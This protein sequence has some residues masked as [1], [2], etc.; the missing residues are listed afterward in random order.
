MPDIG[1]VLSKSGKLYPLKYWRDLHEFRIDL[2]DP[3]AI[4]VV[5]TRSGD[6]GLFGFTES[7]LMADGKTWHC[8]YDDIEGRNTLLQPMEKKQ[9]KLYRFIRPSKAMHLLLAYYKSASVYKHNVN[10]ARWLFWLNFFNTKIICTDWYQASILRSMC[11]L[12]GYNLICRGSYKNLRL[13]RHRKVSTKVKELKRLYSEGTII[14]G[15]NLNSQ[16]FHCN[17]TPTPKQKY[18]ERLM[19][20]L[21]DYK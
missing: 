9:G 12:H 14:H 1:T 7:L 15:L 8:I 17:W 11:D 20:I 6:F 5:L 10:I 4:V 21:D 2:K 13:K 18:T 19:M 16:G 3:E